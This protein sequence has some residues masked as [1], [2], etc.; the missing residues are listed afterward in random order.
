MSEAVLERTEVS[1]LLARAHAVLDELHAADL[2]PLP[3]EELLSYWRGV[4]RLRRRLPTLDHA[5]I[6]EAK[7]RSLPAAVGVRSLPQLL[8]ALLRL[9][10]GEAAARVRAAE[11]A[12]PRRTLTGET[13][14][15][16]FPQVAGA[17]A[18]GAIGERHARTVVE[19]IT[20][21]PEAVR[22][23]HGEQAETDLV[24][25]ARTFD[26]V[27]LGK[28]AHRLAACL[29]PD[30]RYTDLDDRA[31]QRGFTLRRRPDGSAHFEG[32]AT[33]EL[34][35]R[36][37]VTLDS[38]AA[39]APAVDG[40]KDPRTASQRRHDALLAALAML[41]RTGNLPSAGG[42][43][44]T[45][46][47]TM[48][49]EQYQ[50]GNGLAE[51]AHGALIPTREALRWSGG[52]YRLLAVVLDKI[53]GISAYSSSQRLFSEQQRLALWARDGG[54]TY[55][56]CPAPPGQ[57]EVHHLIDWANGGPTSVDN[58]ALA[59]GHDH[60]KL[61]QGWRIQLINGRAAWIPP[62]TIDPQQQPRY[63]YLHRPPELGQ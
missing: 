5:L 40:V 56:D 37:L 13:L 39:P 10:P 53:K 12:G 34:T 51:T 36:L 54:C 41:Q 2:T 27:Q 38:L 44:A 1:V 8:R 21:L 29:D 63:N 45:I 23:E 59:C 31:A 43:A 49:L 52:D 26:P 16:L 22:A 61:D 20:K 15:E 42:V 50:T 48:T 3:Q 14:P 35:E 25:H 9:D 58:G 17:Q 24:A 4:E 32:E 7:A 11:A 33:A 47:L 60:K 62:P 19:T 57:C 46:V 55:P 28:I 30:G 6:A 18:E